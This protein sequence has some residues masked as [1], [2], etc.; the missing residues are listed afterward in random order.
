MR[1]WL[2]GAL[3]MIS[4]FLVLTGDMLVRFL[5]DTRYTLAGP[6]LVLMTISQLPLVILIGNDQIL[7]A[8]GDSKRFMTRV[9]TNAIVQT[10]LLI[11][12]IMQFGLIGAILAPGLAAIL[13]Y[14]ILISAV[15]RYDGWDRTHDIVYATI[16]LI[17]AAAGVW[18]NYA[19][20]AQLFAETVP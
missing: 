14:P 18:V 2:T 7:L 6:I 16:A 20:I 8:A 12:S 11:L 9:A 10:T 17:I 1:W 5:Y 13:V 3:L 19:A 15:R 4:T